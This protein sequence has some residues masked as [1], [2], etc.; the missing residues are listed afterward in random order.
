MNAKRKFRS[1]A[2]K[3]LILE[4]R[5]DFPEGPKGYDEYHYR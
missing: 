2:R 3:L 5:T 1:L 4:S